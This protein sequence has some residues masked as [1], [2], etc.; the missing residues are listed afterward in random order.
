MNFK[1]KGFITKISEIETLDNGAKKL[2]YEINRETE[3]NNLLT[4]EIY[5]TADHAEH[6]TK[7]GEYNKVGDRVEVEFVIRQRE[8]NGKVY[9]NLS[10]W[11]IEKLT[12]E[13]NA[14]NQEKSKSDLDWLND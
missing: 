9:T 5:K 14:L 6:A 10:H 7:F 12:G 13:E 11:K 3:H 8:Y 4:F 2:S 1:T